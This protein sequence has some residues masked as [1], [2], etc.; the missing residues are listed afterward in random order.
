MHADLPD[1]QEKPSNWFAGKLIDCFLYDWPLTSVFN[2]DIGKFKFRKQRNKKLHI[3]A[4]LRSVNFNQTRS[5]YFKKVLKIPHPRKKKKLANTLKSYDS[6]CLLS[7][8]CTFSLWQKDYQLDYQWTTSDYGLLM[9]SFIFLLLEHYEI[10]FSKYFF[11]LIEFLVCFNKYGIII[12]RMQVPL[13][14]LLT[15]SFII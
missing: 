1:I 3:Q 5:D 14:N 9:Q 4:L 13:P 7:V 6:F 8:S 11:S 12:W 2:S 10:L 15:I